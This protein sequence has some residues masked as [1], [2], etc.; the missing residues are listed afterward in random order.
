MESLLFWKQ[1]KLSLSLGTLNKL[2][3]LLCTSSGDPSLITPSSFHW[4]IAPELFLH[5]TAHV[6]DLYLVFACCGT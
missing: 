6:C 2:I 1:V 3:L 4:P 5:C